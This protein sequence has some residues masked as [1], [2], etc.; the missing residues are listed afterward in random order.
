MEKQE[1][2]VIIF[3]D[4]SLKDG[5]IRQFDPTKV[6]VN[7][8]SYG[9]GMPIRISSDEA[10]SRI[11]LE[12]GLNVWKANKGKMMVTFRVAGG[13]TLALSD[14]NLPEIENLISHIP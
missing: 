4:T 13:K 14:P 2:E 11:L 8:S 3:A 10:N 6:K 12:T 5:V 7:K 9:L 1:S